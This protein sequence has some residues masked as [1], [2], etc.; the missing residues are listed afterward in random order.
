MYCV[1][2]CLLALEEKLANLAEMRR[3]PERTTGTTDTIIMTKKRRPAPTET[4]FPRRL[5]RVIGDKVVKTLRSA[6]KEL[7]PK[8][9][10]H[11]RSINEE[12]RYNQHSQGSRDVH[13]EH[14]RPCDDLF[15]GQL[16]WEHGALRR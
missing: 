3:P 14:F 15:T 11:S 5:V 1:V 13:Q 6:S 4:R 2:H 7:F 16:P 9:K 10:F 12:C 8:K